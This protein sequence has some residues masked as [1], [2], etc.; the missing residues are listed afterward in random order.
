[1]VFRIALTEQAELDLEAV[2]AFLTRQNPDAA[3]R[4]GDELVEVAFSLDNLP[5]RG[6]PIR[7]R[8]GV[9]KLVHRDYAIFYRVNQGSRI[10]EILRFWDGRQNPATFDLP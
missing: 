8:P 3:V 10:V 7:G 6:A 4:I 9:R 5:N 1:M 2:V